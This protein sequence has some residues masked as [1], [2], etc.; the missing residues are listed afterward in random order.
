[1]TAGAATA[2]AFAGF[3]EILIPAKTE[4][5]E[6]AI[7]ELQEA[8]DVS[9]D[10]FGQIKEQYKQPLYLT[11]PM[12]LAQLILE[13]SHELERGFAFGTS[14]LPYE[15]VLQM[16]EG[17]SEQTKIKLQSQPAVESADSAFS[18]YQQTV[19]DFYS[20]LVRNEP[21]R[22]GTILMNR[23]VSSFDFLLNRMTTPMGTP[24]LDWLPPFVH[25]IVHGTDP[26]YHYAN[27]DRATDRYY[28]SGARLS[29]ALR[30]DNEWLSFMQEY[31][32]F[33]ELVI[34]SAPGDKLHEFFQ[35]GD[36]WRVI[37]ELN[38][39]ATT[40]YLLGLTFQGTENASVKMQIEPKKLNAIAAKQLS[41]TSYGWNQELKTSARDLLEIRNAMGTGIARAVRRL[42]SDERLD[43]FLKAAGGDVSWYF[44]YPNW[45]MDEHLFHV[46]HTLR[47]GTEIV[48][49]WE[50]TGNM[51][52]VAVASFGNIIRYY[53]HIFWP[54]GRI[55]FEE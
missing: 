10:L 40:N 7:N 25:E 16:M 18:G 6:Y 43:T 9:I 41:M 1:M 2:A 5:S 38:A 50:D 20:S 22:I 11:S 34:F 44:Q 37:N 47:D 48:W 4:A 32:D 33:M 13:H 52:Y 30:S 49:N 26:S 39:M 14:L 42:I 45:N 28:S 19:Q 36:I 29:L 31:Q 15:E 53:G 54:H 23:S 24:Q 55:F 21:G 46:N 12:F 3:A 27:Y 17:P 8:Y 35:Q 51:E